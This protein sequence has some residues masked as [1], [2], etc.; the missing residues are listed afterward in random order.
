MPA[1]E[2]HQGGGGD[3]RPEHWGAEPCRWCGWQPEPGNILPRPTYADE[4]G[5]D[6][7]ARFQKQF[8]RSVLGLTER[9]Q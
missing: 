3:C 2:T 4:P 5:D 8:M 9:Q 7:S 6:E 1:D